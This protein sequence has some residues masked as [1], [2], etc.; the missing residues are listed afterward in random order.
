MKGY[1][2]AFFKEK[3]TERKA[4]LLFIDSILKNVENSWPATSR[5]LKV[6][7]EGRWNI[8]DEG[9]TMFDFVL[10]ATA[11]DLQAVRNLFPS[12]QAER[13]ERFVMNTLSGIEGWGDY[14]ANEVGEYG[15]KFQGEIH[16]LSTGGD[17][18]S[19]IPARL[20]HRWLGEDFHVCE[21]VISGKRTG[22]IDVFLLS[23]VTLLVG[24]YVGMWKSI[25]D[26]Y[27]IVEGD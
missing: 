20:L 4:A 27:K 8:Q 22:C 18:F 25:K 15:A 26:T 7:F 14:A 1:F 17:P 3:L 23:T 2:M 12:Y 10:A 16:T 19:A 5:T 21:G 11:Q 6:S 24:Q 13:I 9:A